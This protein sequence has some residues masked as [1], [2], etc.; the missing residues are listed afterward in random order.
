M[1]DLNVD[2]EDSGTSKSSLV[3]LQEEDYSCFAFDILKRRTE[4]EIEKQEE[5][6]IRT[7]TLFPSSIE[8]EK[9]GVLCSRSNTNNNN[10]NNH[11]QWL[12]LWFEANN[13]GK[14]N[15]NNSDNRESE[16]RMLEQNKQPQMRKSRRGPRSRS[17][18]YRG[19]T[20][21]RR[22]GRWESHIWYTIT[23]PIITF[24]FLHL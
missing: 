9:L 1:L 14:N 16:L 20:F 23:N 12:N 8:D 10:N 3:N 5:G 15:N 18:Q 11:H 21:Y 17:S 2:M 22:T 4:E 19:V 13:N 6:E 24:F 7:R